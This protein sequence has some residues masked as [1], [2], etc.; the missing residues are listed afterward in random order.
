[1]VPI[2]Y[3]LVEGG[4]ED[5]V[6]LLRESPQLL[7]GV[8]E[9]CCAHREWDGR[10]QQ[11]TRMDRICRICWWRSLIDDMYEMK[12]G[13][14]DSVANCG[15]LISSEDLMKLIKVWYTPS[16]HIFTL[17][18][19]NSSACK[20][21]PTSGMTWSGWLDWRDVNVFCI[22][23]RFWSVDWERD[24]ILTRICSLPMVFVSHWSGREWYR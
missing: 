21:S 6:L 16:I 18:P 1:M 11:N 15:R 17:A 22:W 8:Q 9:R 23:R 13:L 4:W 2:G 19:L 7:E 14:M 3:V 5:E 20:S 24:T 10:V 12:C